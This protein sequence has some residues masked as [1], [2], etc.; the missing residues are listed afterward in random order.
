MNKPSCDVFLSHDGHDKPAVEA[1][2]PPLLRLKDAKL[3][4]SAAVFSG[5]GQRVLLL[6]SDGSARFW[7]STSGEL[8]EPLSIHDGRIDGAVLSRDQ[9][10]VLTWSADATVRL[11]AIDSGKPIMPA[12]PHDGERVNGAVFNSDETRIL[13]WAEDG[14]ARVWSRETGQPLTLPMKHE[15]AVNGARFLPDENWI[16]TWAVDSTVRL[17]SLE[18]DES[19]FDQPVLHTKL[20]TGTKLT[21]EREE[22]KILDRKE[23]Q[24]AR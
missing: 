9:R 10:S 4:V 23:W 19:G 15:Y 22:L 20:R 21:K 11:W 16:M 6:G 24:G 14:T 17:W 2:A 1:L 12:L 13:T 8:D 3:R 5:D 18:V 7:D